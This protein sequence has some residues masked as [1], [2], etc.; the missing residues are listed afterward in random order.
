MKK[1]RHPN[2]VELVGVCW[3]DDLFACCLEFVENG[4]L[5]DWLRRTAGGKVHLLDSS[6]STLADRVSAGWD[7]LNQ[8][9]EDKFTALDLQKRTEL[10]DTLKRFE[11]ELNVTR[12]RGGG[13]VNAASGKT[14]KKEELSMAERLAKAKELQGTNQAQIEKDVGSGN[15][16]EPDDNHWAHGASTQTFAGSFFGTS[17]ESNGWTAL[18]GFPS[19][20][21]FSRYREDDEGKW[22]EA[23]AR[24]EINAPPSQVAALHSSPDFVGSDTTST[25]QWLDRG[26]QVSHTY[27]MLPSTYWVL[28]NRDMMWRHICGHDAGAF[29]TVLYSVDDERRP[30]QSGVKRVTMESAHLIT[31][32]AGSEGKL[33][34]VKYMRRIDLKISAAPRAVQ[35]LAAKLSVEATAGP[36]DKL[37][38]VAEELM[39]GHVKKERTSVEITW[40]GQLLQIAV[41]CALGVQ[42]LHHERY[43]AEEEVQ[44]K[45]VV[46]EAG[47]RECIIHR[48]LKPDNMLLTKDWKLKLTDFGEARA[49]NLNASMTSVGTPIY[50]APEVMR[51]YQ[52]NASCDSYS[53]G[54]IL[55]AMIR[56]EKNVI[57]FYF[58]ALRKSMKRKTKNG[59]GITIL[60]TRMYAKASRGGDVLLRFALC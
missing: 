55:V 35:A 30:E 46:V 5:E 58:Q 43:W 10:L 34:V 51:G 39:G 42:Y 53:F 1:L 26:L 45:G 37:K 44:E 13:S 20:S 21:S 19:V 24:V 60:N 14:A 29:F 38:R 23:L 22:A 18:S 17:K 16:A 36:L 40:K 6:E 12:Q 57:E 8:Y 59:V 47:Y 11:K 25:N 50:A 33:S 27:F 28:S 52:Y 41:E 49:V 9:D 54:I 7:P 48:D 15:V 56:G 3:D 2:I 32:K 31:E 4:S